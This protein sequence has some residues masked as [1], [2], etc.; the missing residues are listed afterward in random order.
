[1][2]TTTLSKHESVT[3]N[4]IGCE[5]DCVAGDIIKRDFVSIGLQGISSLGVNDY[6]LV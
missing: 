1:M 3:I 6:S 4:V 5:E 2:L